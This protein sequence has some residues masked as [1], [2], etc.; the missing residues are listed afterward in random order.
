M[1]T[2]IKPKRV[3]REVI[4]AYELR[5]GFTGIGEFFVKEGLL[6]YAEEC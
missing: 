6:E 1:K 4:R 3:S 2:E 5:T